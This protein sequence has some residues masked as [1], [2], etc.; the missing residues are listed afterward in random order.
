MSATIENFISN[1]YLLIFFAIVVFVMISKP[2]FLE[3]FFQPEHFKPDICAKCASILSSCDPANP[4]FK[5]K[6]CQSNCASSSTST[7]TSEPEHFKPDICAKCASILSSCNPANPSSR[8]KMCQR[9]CP[10]ASGSVALGSVA[11][12]SVSSD[13][14]ASD[15]ATSDTDTSDTTTSENFEPTYESRSRK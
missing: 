4:S 9:K 2:K 15:P 12:D 6:F 10:T 5:C 14:V 13:S 11:S 7:S 8:C 1:N 3:K